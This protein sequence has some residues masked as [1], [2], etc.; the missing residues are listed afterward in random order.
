MP[1]TPASET[2]PIRWSFE[3]RPFTRPTTPPPDAVGAKEA[4]GEELVYPDELLV[5]D[6]PRADV[7]VADLA[8]A[9]DSV[10]QPDVQSARLH[11]RHG[12]A[13]VKHVVAR[14]FRQ[15][16]GVER[17]LLRMGILPPAVADDEHYGLAR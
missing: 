9:H 3:D 12:I 14:L 16:G 10:R 4:V 5:H 11:E 8:V 2:M 17:I 6:P 15:D 1:W 13:G 7:L